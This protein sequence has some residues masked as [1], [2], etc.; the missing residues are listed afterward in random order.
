[1]KKTK[2]IYWVLTAMVL[3]PSAGS[4]IPELFTP[5]PEQVVKGLL[6]LGYPLYLL[7]ILGVAKILGTLAL[8]T[9]RFPRLKEWAYAGFAIEFLGAA[10]SHV[11]ANDAANAL[12]PLIFFAVL[13]ASYYFYNRIKSEE[14]AS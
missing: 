1:M 2:I 7:K 9:N 4:A 12:M 3:L 10:A 13:M 5:G 6:T 8:V 14:T 11:L